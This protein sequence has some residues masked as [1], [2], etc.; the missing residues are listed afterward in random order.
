ME[1]VTRSGPRWRSLRAG[2]V[3]GRGVLLVLLLVAANLVFWGHDPA[4]MSVNPHPFFLAVC[5]AAVWQGRRGG[6]AAA[7]VAAGAGAVLLVASNTVTLYEISRSASYLTISLSLFLTGLVLGAIADA[8][9]KRYQRLRREHEET[10]KRFKEF[11]CAYQLM[12][13]AK[14][15]LENRI[16]ELTNSFTTIFDEVKNLIGLGRRKLIVELV[17]LLNRYGNAEQLAAYSVTEAGF[18]LEAELGHTDMLAPTIGRT[19]RPIMAHAMEAKKMVTLRDV[20]KLEGREL[21]QCDAL[22]AV[23][24]L[25]AR[26]EVT[27][28]VT[29]EKIPF[30]HFNQY[31]LNVIALLCEWAGSLLKHQG[32]ASD[33]VAQSLCD[34]NLGIY[35]EK[36]LRERLEE[37]VSRSTRYHLPLSACTI[38]LAPDIDFKGLVSLLREELREVDVMAVTD[39]LEE[40][41]VLLPMTPPEGAEIAAVRIMDEATAKLGMEVECCVVDLATLD[42]DEA[43]DAVRGVAV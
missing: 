42:P 26:G 20:L 14:E 37:E 3:A 8:R 19:D 18:H 24:L 1:R 21:A 9:Q 40:L 13:R 2:I 23:P 6:V 4:F 33:L 25:D 16:L 12:E 31:S 28:V 10:T 22:A 39:D 38:A 27:V 17:H 15:E 41:V 43:Y 7:V 11:D 36:Y 35:R 5:V 32:K 34:P 29:I 30:M